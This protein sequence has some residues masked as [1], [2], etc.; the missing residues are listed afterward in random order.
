MSCLFSSG[1]DCSQ[2]YIDTKDAQWLCKGD[3]VPLNEKHVTPSQFVIYRFGIF[4][5]ELLHKSAGTPMVTLL[6]ASNL[7]RNNYKNNAF[8]H[9]IYYEH[10]RKILFI[11]HE[12]MESIG[13]FI[14]VILHSLAHLKVGEMTDDASAPFLK[15]FYK[16][17]FKVICW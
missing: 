14:V 10:K 12:R 4:M 3:L 5:V 1:A 9:S 6:L 11:R 8:R 15:E 16:V 13:D 17:G 2:S 7:P